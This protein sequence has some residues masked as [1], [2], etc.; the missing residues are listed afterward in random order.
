VPSLRRALPA[1]LLALA[2][3]TAAAPAGAAVPGVNV[4]DHTFAASDAGVDKIA[5]SGAKNVRLFLRRSD[6]Q[7]PGGGQIRNEYVDAVT[8]LKARGIDTTFVVLDGASA[9]PPNPQQYGDFLV[10][11]AN[12]NGIKGVAL[13]YE[14]WNEVDDPNPDGSFWQQAPAGR[15]ATYAALVNTV[16]A[17]LKAEVTPAPKVSLAPFVGNNYAF[18]DQLYG[19]GLQNG[20]FDVVS[21]HTD[22]A[23]LVRSPHEFYR[24]DSTTAPGY[25]GRIGRYSFMAYREV[26]ETM[27]A[28]GAGDKK[29]WATE[30]GW[31]STGELV[32]EQSRDPKKHAAGAKAGVSAADQAEYLI[33]AFNCFADDPYVELAQWF[34]FYDLTTP[35]LPTEL[36]NYGLLANDRTTPKP[37]LGAFQAVAAAPGFDPRPEACGADFRPPTVQIRRPTPGFQFVD[38]LDI[39]AVATDNGGVGFARSGEQAGRATFSF[40]GGREIRNFTGADF[41]EGKTIALTPWNGAKDLPLGKHT[42]EVT[43]LDRNGNPGVAKVEVEKVKTLAATLTPTFKLGKVKCKRR[44]CSLAGSLVRGIP[45]SPS[46]G[47]KVRIAWEV[48]RGGRWRK[49]SGGLKPANKRFTFVL[50]RAKFAGR[51]RAKVTYD[52]LAPW[53]KAAAKP[54]AFRVR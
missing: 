29:I 15:P 14:L 27:K 48:N 9:A 20:A 18:L 10:D 24:E 12:T 50:K 3:L 44:R 16:G 26:F 13:G 49:L 43:A 7:G 35:G 42:I 23:C 31:S 5:A 38:K 54:V 45:G 47:G 17:R 19:A 37:A 21:V 36:K 1:L 28:R 2:A 30:I 33:R 40:N 41:A 11:F 32:C 46:L 6:I 25:E 52:G 51:W 4:A 8:K 53:K 39:E 22:T 34:T